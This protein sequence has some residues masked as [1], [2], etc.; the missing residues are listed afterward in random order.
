[1]KKF[2]LLC[3]ALLPLVAFAQE[4]YK[5]FLKEGKRWNYEFEHVNLWE[6]IDITEYVSF[7]IEGDEVI[8]GKTYKKLYRATSD[9]QF[10]ALEEKTLH[11]YL[12][13]EGQKV[14]MYDEESGSD[15]L[16]FDFGMQ[17]GD[18]YELAYQ[19]AD[20][21]LKLVS[22]KQQTFH[23]KELTVFKYDAIR[24]FIENDFTEDAYIIEG[25]GGRC[26]WDIVYEFT[27]FPTNGIYVLHNFKSCY[28][29]GECI[30]TSD[31]FSVIT[32]IKEAAAEQV[33]NDIHDAIYDLQGR[34]L[35]AI[36][37]QGIYIR[38]GKKYVADK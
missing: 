6:D 14:L 25:V 17:H 5:P 20:I 27:D 7:I 19:D 28:E 22:T 30:F 1:M 18:Y 16:L 29:D 10:S 15:L 11:K 2:C 38:G 24:R 36:P 3:L 4:A 8:D 34:Q 32:G 23:D 12:R 35:P 13:E 33:G 26:G 31:D 37:S 21:R 9:E